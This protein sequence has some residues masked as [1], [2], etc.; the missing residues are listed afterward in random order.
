MLSLSRKTDY[1]LIAL[2]HMARSPQAC[3]SAREIA[4]RYGIPL[5][6]LMNVLKQ[7]AQRGLTRSV[8]GSRGGY[9][10]AMPAD[11]ITLNA[12][13]DAV[14]GPIQ[15]VQCVDWYEHRLR[16]RA[17]AGCEL[18]AACPVRKTIHQVHHRLVEFL[19]TV[20]LADVIDGRGTSGPHPAS[21]PDELVVSNTAGGKT[22]EAHDLPG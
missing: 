5:P 12:I 15:L 14:E 10:L 8:R 4:T 2:T 11:R 13:I 17:R 18:M 7:T 3:N 1:A 22:D 9:A 6:L 20:S 21:E 19:D 16:G